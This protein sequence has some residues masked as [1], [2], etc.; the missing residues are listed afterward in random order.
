MTDAP[1]KA[2]RKATVRSVKPGQ[3]PGPAIPDYEDARSA[4]RPGT[5]HQPVRLTSVRTSLRLMRQFPPSS[6]G[7]SFARLARPSSPG[8]R[9][10]MPVGVHW[11]SAAPCSSILPGSR[12]VFRARNAPAAPNR[13]HRSPPRDRYPEWDDWHSPRWAAIL[14]AGADHPPSLRFAGNFVTHRFLR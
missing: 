13:R 7:M 4:I 11:R 12:F 9:Q 5:V 10:R 1:A 3:P 14:F 2:R 6:L 8:M